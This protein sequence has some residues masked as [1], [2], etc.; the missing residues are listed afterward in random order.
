M[1][2]TDSKRLRG[3]IEGLVA[4]LVISLAGAIIVGVYAKPEIRT[5]VGGL[6]GA[7]TIGLVL[8]LLLG[9][10][11]GATGRTIGASLFVGAGW[12]VTGFVLY[13]WF[14]GED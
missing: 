14:Y 8:A 6:K 9:S 13:A 7:C 3:I 12:L 11:G 10:I 4:G 1:A 2:S 5:F